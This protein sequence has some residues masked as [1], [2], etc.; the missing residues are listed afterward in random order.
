MATHP[1]LV[2]MLPGW[3]PGEALPSRQFSGYVEVKRALWH[4]HLTEA[5]LPEPT[6]APLVLYVSGGPVHSVPPPATLKP[7]LPFSQASLLYNRR[8]VAAATY[9]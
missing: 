1:D 2:S 6:A 7:P 9:M 4:Y 5:E 8:A 3:P